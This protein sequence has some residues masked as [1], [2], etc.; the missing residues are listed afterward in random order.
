MDET[1]WMFFAV[2][3]IAQ[4]VDGALG[5]AFGVTATTVM[6]SFGT[7]PAQA[8]AMVHIAEMFT[9]AASGASHWWHRNVDWTIVRR[10][11]IPGTVGGVLGATL[12]DG[13][14][15]QHAAQF[16]AMRHSETFLF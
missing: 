8:S 15:S 11:A 4:G 9:T 10:I 6:L 5:M 16:Q 3:V 12:L 7:P 1:W 2:G 14:R 13:C